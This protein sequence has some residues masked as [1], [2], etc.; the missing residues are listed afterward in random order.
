MT[1]NRDTSPAPAIQPGLMVVHGNRLEDLRDLL[2]AWLAKA[3]LAPLEDELMLVQSNG[4]AQWLKMALARAPA[5][6]GMGISAAV[7]M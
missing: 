4:I 3:P 2:L 1:A 5:A 6:G 7:D